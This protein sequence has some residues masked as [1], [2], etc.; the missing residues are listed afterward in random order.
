MPSYTDLVSRIGEAGAIPADRPVDHTRR[1][2]TG[3]FAGVLAGMF[4]GIIFF[5]AS[6][7]IVHYP[8]LLI[9]VVLAGVALWYV[10]KVVPTPRTGDPV[11][12]VARTLATTESPFSRL[13]RGGGHSGLL[14]PVVVAPVDGSA[15]FTSVILLRDISQTNLSAEPPVGSL[16]PFEQVEPGMGELQNIEQVTPEQQA[17]IERLRKHP[18][19]LANK[20]P[21]LPMRRGALERTPL[22]AGIQWWGSIALGVFL[23]AIFAGLLA[24]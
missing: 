11:P 21:A 8:L 17:L 22:W 3:L 6:L 1:L 15:S 10:W 19:E 20:A 16:F 2:V 24:R 14:V 13:V 12:V 5:A 18:R 9:P 7:E 4:V 23:M